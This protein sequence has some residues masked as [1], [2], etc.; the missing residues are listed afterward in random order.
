MRT[1]LIWSRSV[2]KEIDGSGKL[3]KDGEFDGSGEWIPLVS[4]DRSYVKGMTADEVKEGCISARKDF[5]RWS[6]IA[7][8][9]MDGVNAGSLYMGAKFFMIILKIVTLFSPTAAAWR[10]KARLCAL[11][12]VK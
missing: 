6:S 8:R 1:G 10:R 2:A 4:G 3:P 5:Y 11:E 7:R 9:S 12:P